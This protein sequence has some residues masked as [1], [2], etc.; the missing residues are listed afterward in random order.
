MANKA[1]KTKTIHF[2]R[3]SISFDVNVFPASGHIAYSGFGAHITKKN[4]S[5]RRNNKLEAKRA[6][7]DK[8]D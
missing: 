1:K 8:N 2:G 3:K 4:R 6:R 5:E 7:F